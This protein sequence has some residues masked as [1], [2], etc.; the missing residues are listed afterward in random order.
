MIYRDFR[1]AANR[2]LQTCKYMCEFLNCK[3]N[4]SEKAN[5]I[6]DIYYLSGY[7]I[8]CIIKYAIYDYIKYDPKADVADLTP[9]GKYKQYNISYKGN[10]IYRTQTHDLQH[11]KGILI[12]INGNDPFIG[13]S[14][15]KLT[16]LYKGW[17]S[18]VRYKIDHDLKQELTES[19]VSQ[20]IKIVDEKIYKK[21]SI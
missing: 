6:T 15:S 9:E 2:H 18:E 12:F 17:H 13:M 5:I 11:L 21:M 20:F 14:S 3:P 7:V 10:T 1:I 19:N 8:E 16:T 4:E